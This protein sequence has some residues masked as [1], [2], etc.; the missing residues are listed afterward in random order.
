MT[1]YEDNYITPAVCVYHDNKVYSIEV[2]L[3]GVEKENIDFQMS[4]NWFCLKAQREDEL[5]SGCWM[6]AHNIKPQIAKAKFK[7]GLLSIRAPQEDM[8]NEGIKINVE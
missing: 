8:A 3:P 1:E 6:L 5:Y 4:E 2:E 7:D